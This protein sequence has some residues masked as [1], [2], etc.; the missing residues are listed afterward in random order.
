V[1]AFAAVS[2]AASS[3]SSRAIQWHLR[4]VRPRRRFV[5]VVTVAPARACARVRSASAAQR[6]G[7]SRRQGLTLSCTADVVTCGE[8]VSNAGPRAILKA[9]PERTIRFEWAGPAGVCSRLRADVRR[10]EFFP[11]PSSD[12]RLVSYLSI[13]HSNGAEPA[14]RC[15]T[16]R[17]V[18]FSTQ[19]AQD[20]KKL[21]GYATAPAPTARDGKPA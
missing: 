6:L 8:Q 14:P 21:S 17:Q 10:L 7:L 16:S 19:A 3:V 2:P 9:W 13:G 5:K 12:L 15:R 18:R 20:G 1:P 11:D 4:H